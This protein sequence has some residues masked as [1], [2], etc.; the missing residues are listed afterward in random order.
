MARGDVKITIVPATTALHTGEANFTS[1]SLLTQFVN[2]NRPAN[3]D[4][5]EVDFRGPRA[6]IIYREHA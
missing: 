6:I 2:D 4:V 3:H 5:I 1:E